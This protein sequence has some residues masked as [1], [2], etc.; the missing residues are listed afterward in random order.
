MPKPRYVSTIDLPDKQ[1][2]RSSLEDAID[3]DFH[4]I[5]LKKE[6]YEKEKLPK[7]EDP[8]RRREK[9]YSEVGIRG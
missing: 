8:H 4:N 5:S 2:S 3:K 9:I 6:L 7:I 1:N